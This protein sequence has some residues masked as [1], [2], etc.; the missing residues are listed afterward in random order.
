M[1]PV[2]VQVRGELAP[3]RDHLRELAAILARA[4][5][6]VRTLDLDLVA[7]RAVLEIH[8]TDGRW[9]YL[10]ADSIGRASV[11]RWHREATVE[12]C[13]G[14]GPQRD[15]HRDQFLGRMRFE[16]P[17]AALRHLSRYVADNPAPGWAEIEV[18]DVRGVLAPLMAVPV[19]VRGS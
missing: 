10:S 1:I 9:L 3:A 8:R 4:G 18:G 7:G 14:D 17:R 2:A 13:F 19:R 6:E 16:G 15:G 5:W 11:E 12:R